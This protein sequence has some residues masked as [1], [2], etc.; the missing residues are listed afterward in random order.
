MT[1]SMPQ[2]KQKKE[3]TFSQAEIHGSKNQSK[4]PKKCM[5][6]NPGKCTSPFL[7]KK[8]RQKMFGKFPWKFWPRKFHCDKMLHP[9][10]ESASLE[11]KRG[12]AGLSTVILSILTD[13]GNQKATQPA[14]ELA[15]WGERR[16]EVGHPPREHFS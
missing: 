5:I 15:T 10:N 4:Q 16:V 9:V 14:T 2:R 1:L 7:A 11:T 3:I 8:N 13:P 12:Y 6:I